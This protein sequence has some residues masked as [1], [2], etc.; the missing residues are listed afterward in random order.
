[1][2]YHV[3]KRTISTRIVENESGINYRVFAELLAKNI[4]EGIHN[5]RGRKV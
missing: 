5:E 3:N 4:M 1:M 2:A